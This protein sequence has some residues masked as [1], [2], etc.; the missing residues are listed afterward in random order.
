MKQREERDSHKY[1]ARIVR[2]H[3]V[4]RARISEIV[5][6]MREG[7]LKMQTKDFL[8]SLHRNP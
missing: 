8:A 2:F 5:C 3:V 6:P 7:G 1:L 4:F